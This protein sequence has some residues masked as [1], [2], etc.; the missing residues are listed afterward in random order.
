MVNF[1]VGHQILLLMDL[2]IGQQH[3]SGIADIRPGVNG[4]ANQWD[5]DSD[6]TQVYWNIPS[7]HLL[8]HPVEDNIEAWDWTPNT[9]IYLT[10]GAYS[11]LQFIRPTD[12]FILMSIHLT[13]S[14]GNWWR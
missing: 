7:P 1:L 9:T 11:A 5:E 13:S 10:I 12:G 8:V 2:E 14:L 3:F 4:G 6:E